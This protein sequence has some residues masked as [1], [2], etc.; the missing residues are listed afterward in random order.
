MF[1]FDPLRSNKS[2][3]F[4]II[5][6]LSAFSLNAQATLTSYANDGVDL[7]YSSASDVTWTKDASLLGTMIASSDYDT[8]VSAIIANTPRMTVGNFNLPLTTNDFNQFGQTSWLG[9][10]AFVNYLNKTSYGGINNWYLPTVANGSSGF[11]TSTNGTIRG[12]ELG[13]LF[14]SELAGTA[15]QAIPNTTTFDNEQAYNYWTGTAFDPNNFIA[16]AYL[17]GIGYQGT[18]VM[19]NQFWVWAVSPGQVTAVPEPESLAMMLLGLG[20]VGVVVRRRR[21]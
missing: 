6:A 4:A 15:G 19:R 1:N 3:L 16:W 14:Y 12:D 9:G 17:N 18:S 13:E 11:N 21:G 7:V 5:F 8:V 20:V 10:V 2:I